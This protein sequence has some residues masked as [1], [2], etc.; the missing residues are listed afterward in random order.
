[1]KKKE[2]VIVI[3]SIIVVGVLCYYSG[4]SKGVYDTFKVIA[5]NAEELVD[6]KLTT[7]AHQILTSNMR[8]AQLIFEAES[9]DK[10]LNDMNRSGA[11]KALG[12]DWY[13]VQEFV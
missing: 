3:L 8:L 11:S 4:Y 9:L 6:I 10:M 7:R 1:M 13:L 12:P 5:E 2:V